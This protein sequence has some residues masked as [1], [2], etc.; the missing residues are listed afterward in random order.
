MAQDRKGLVY[1]LMRT[2]KDIHLRVA[3]AKVQLTGGRPAG[4]T[5][6]SCLQPVL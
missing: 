5:F 1:D 4:P 6:H 2:F 3:Y